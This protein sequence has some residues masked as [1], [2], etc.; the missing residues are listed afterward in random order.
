M[1]R[2]RRKRLRLVLLAIVGIGATALSLFAYQQDLFRRQELDTVD[3]RFEIR[4]KQ[5]V[6]A[7]LV[8]VAIDD[9]TFSDLRVRWP[10]PR[11]YHARVIDRLRRAGA[12]VI[13]YD[14]QFTEPSRDPKEDLALYDAVDRAGNVVLATTEVDGRGRTAI[15]G[16]DDNLRRAG[17]RPANS[18]LPNDPGG[19][20]RRFDHSVD[21]LKT[22]GVVTAEVATGKAV[23]PSLFGGE[24]AWID[25]LGPPD[26]I[27]QIPFSEVYEGKAGPATFR[28]KVV[29]VGPTAPSLQDVHPTSTSGDGVM[30]GAEIQAS[31]SWT[32]QRGLPLHPAAGWLNVMLIAIMGLVIPAFSV[33]LS[34]LRSMLFALGSV[35]A[36]LVAAQLMFNGGR[37]VAVLYPL[38]A[39]VLAAVGALVVHY[40]VETR[41][42]RRL[43]GLFARFV[44]EKVV[45]EVVDRTDD[46]LRLGGVRVECTVLFSD[47]RG[48]TT[49]SEMQPAER[50][51]DILNYYF[52]EMSE[53]I[54]DN[55]GTLLGYLGDGIIAVFGAP[56]E[57]GD[58]ADRALT[59]AREMIGERLDRFNS[60]LATEGIDAFGIGVGLN[61]GPVMAGN[62]GSARRLEYT[63]IGDTVNT[64]ARLEAMTKDT[65]HQLFFGDATRSMLR[66]DPGDLVYVDSMS[67]RGRHESVDVWTLRG[68]DGE[69]GRAER[70]SVRSARVPNDP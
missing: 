68:D 42:R 41:E 65:P 29:I 47:I 49:F 62:V 10:F 46:D 50:V 67:V 43:R 38:I 7:D 56:I 35:A 45:D 58:H 31:A 69:G 11:T 34:P 60:W 36:F 33:R 44:P 54:L 66:S 6:P 8:V 2:E 61:S 59:A 30:S 3:Q 22:F 15:L 64:A 52:E 18:L 28:N 12:R 24:A 63:A 25:Y 53:A 14:V 32:V 48:F 4:G 40:F 13:G 27:T 55:G 37:I 70:E 9:V 16:G 26:T 21:G 5:K 20:I 51:I 17:A 39:V 57:Q 23:T 1:L 19:V